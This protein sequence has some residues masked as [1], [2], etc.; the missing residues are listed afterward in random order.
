MFDHLEAAAWPGLQ[1]MLFSVSWQ[2]SLLNFKVC[3]THKNKSLHQ[4]TC[5]P[6]K[7]LTIKC[8]MT[9]SHGQSPAPL[10][11]VTRKPAHNMAMHRH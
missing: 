2:A 5:S 10:T 3:G 8:L 11:G 6:V 7:A 9:S 1:K 4:G